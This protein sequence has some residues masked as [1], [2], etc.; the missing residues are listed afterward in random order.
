MTTKPPEPA[1]ESTPA[2]L[3]REIAWLTETFE[4][5]PLPAGP[6]ELRSA[7]GAAAERIAALVLSTWM[8]DYDERAVVELLLREDDSSLP[9]PPRFSV[10]AYPK[11]DDA[12]LAA[13]ARRSLSAERLVTLQE[14]ANKERLEWEGAARR[15]K[16]GRDALG[17]FER[18]SP[19]VVRLENEETRERHE[20]LAASENLQIE[21]IAALG[22]FPPMQ[23]RLAAQTLLGLTDTKFPRVELLLDPLTGGIGRLGSLL[24]R[25][26]IATALLRLRSAMEVAFPGALGHRS[27]GPAIAGPRGGKDEAQSPFRARPR[28]ESETPLAA[29]DLVEHLVG[30]LEATGVVGQLER[31][32]AHGFMLGVIA[33]RARER[34]R[35]IKLVDRVAFWSDSDAELESKELAARKR[36]HNEVYARVAEDA[37]QRVDRLA[38]P[39]FLTALRNQILRCYLAL[40]ALDTQLTTN[41]Y[42]ELCCPIPQRLPAI[43]ALFDLAAVVGNRWGLSG[44]RDELLHHVAAYLR[45]THAGPSPFELL[46]EHGR[47]PRPLS[48]HEVVVGT[49]EALRH[50]PLLALMAQYD[51][52]RRRY[53]ADSAGAIAAARSMTFWDELEIF[54]RS[55]KKDAKV[56]LEKS[57]RLDWIGAVQ[58][59]AQ[60]GAL[61]ERGL[62]MYPPAQAYYELTP[63]RQ[64]FEAVRSEVRSTGMGNNKRYYCV[65]LGKNEALGALRGWTQRAIAVFGRMPSSGEI[66]ERFTYKRLWAR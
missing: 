18:S 47:L 41:R 57:A 64:A 9:T 3:A 31:C 53:E 21:L 60:L 38:A 36:W 15:L 19:D 22:A 1:T 24:P 54:S 14:G 8:P 4:R 35:D 17:L 39:H 50:S 2:L 45:H 7:F 30:G 32:L 48:Q 62:D 63:V 52:L 23:I 20:A 66:I 61:L 6:H 49:A 16:A 26:V 56:A 28:E 59:Q 65:L 11:I 46:R 34:R 55:P 25:A 5:S 29:P 10:G 13:L 37:L 51:E 42:N 44:G 27:G 58:V 33:T 43:G 12:A 40:L